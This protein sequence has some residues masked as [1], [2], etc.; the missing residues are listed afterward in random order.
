MYTGTNI[1]DLMINVVIGAVMTIIFAGAFI[2]GFYETATP[3]SI[4]NLDNPFD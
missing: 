4:A 3:A 1:V 2:F